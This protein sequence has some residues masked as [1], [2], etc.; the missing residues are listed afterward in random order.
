MRQNRGTL[1]TCF[2]PLNQPQKRVAS[3]N[4]RPMCFHRG[5]VSV[6]AR[7]QTSQTCQGRETRCV[8]KTPRVFELKTNVSK[9]GFT[10][11]LQETWWFVDPSGK[12]ALKS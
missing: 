7:L 11:Y 2:A 10:C 8:S 5:K 1:K 6:L 9:K 3:K 12:H 4:D